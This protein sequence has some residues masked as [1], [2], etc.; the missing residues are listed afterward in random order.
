V[1]AVVCS[2]RNDLHGREGDFVLRNS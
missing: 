2:E 1:I